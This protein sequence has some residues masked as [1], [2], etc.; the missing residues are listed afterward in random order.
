VDDAVNFCI[1]F[2]ILFISHIILPHILGTPIVVTPFNFAQG[3]SNSCMFSHMVKSEF[4]SVDV[5]W[6]LLRLTS[7]STISKDTVMP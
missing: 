4:S 5:P 7:S 6:K 1:T 3:S 2:R